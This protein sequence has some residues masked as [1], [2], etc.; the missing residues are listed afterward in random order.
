MKIIHAIL[1]HI[2]IYFSL[3]VNLD[4]NVNKLSKIHIISSQNSDIELAVNLRFSCSTYNN[5]N[6]IQ[7]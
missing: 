7:N 6:D 4:I 3:N 1:N 5:V 2:F